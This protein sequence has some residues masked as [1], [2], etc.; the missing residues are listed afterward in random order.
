MFRFICL[1]ILSVMLV[2]LSSNLAFA[3]PGGE[4]R[5]RGFMSFLDRNKNGVIEVSELD[6]MPGR[7]KES[8]QAAGVDTSRDIS[9]QEFERIMP[10]LMERMRSQRGS[11]GGSD[12]G[13][14]GEDRRRSSFS[15][16]PDG[17]SGGF[18]RRDGNSD[19]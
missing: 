8:L 14:G 5:T 19:D 13:R 7:F 3:Q 17:P 18:S 12:R 6:R 16:G 9:Q 4:S 2:G 15:R 10:Q 1:L 11:S